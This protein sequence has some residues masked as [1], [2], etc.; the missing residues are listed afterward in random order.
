MQGNNNDHCSS[1]RS[2]GALV[3]C[4]GCPRAFH[5]WC[6]D[7]PMESIDEGDSRWF[8]PACVI[9]KVRLS[10]AGFD[11]PSHYFSRI[12][13]KCRNQPLCLLSSTS[14]KHRFRLSSNYLTTSGISSAMVIKLH[15]PLA[16]RLTESL[17]VTTGPKGTYVDA[18][19]VKPPRLK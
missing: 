14:S 10:P 12:R 13:P 19:E 9:K 4:D 8:C 17:P 18:T 7:P 6:L 5:L 2:N 1:C 16:D 11:D 3:Y 15:F